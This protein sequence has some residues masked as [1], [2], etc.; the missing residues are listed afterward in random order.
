MFGRQLTH[1][2]WVA[3]GLAMLAGVPHL[4]VAIAAIVAL[5]AVFAAWQEFRADHSTRQLRALLPAAVRVIRDGAQVL[6]EVPDLVVDDVVLLTAGDRVGADMQ[7]TEARS[8]S[9]DE[10]MVTGES[11]GVPRSPGDR[12]GRRDVRDER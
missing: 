2:L 9:M 10:S 3:S 5:N 8:L 12:L 6:I 4:A 1:L 11:G 7:V